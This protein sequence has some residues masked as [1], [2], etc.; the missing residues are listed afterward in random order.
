MS[1]VVALFYK[2]FRSGVIVSGQ[3]ETN[4]HHHLHPNKY[5]G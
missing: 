2:I 4:A 1:V 3:H 5:V